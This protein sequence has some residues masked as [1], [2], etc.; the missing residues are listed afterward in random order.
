ML[1]AYRIS[2]CMTLQDCSLKMYVN[3]GEESAWLSRMVSSLTGSYGVCLQLV[4]MVQERAST[5]STQQTIHTQQ[6]VHNVM[7]P[8]N[9]DT[10]SVALRLN[11]EQ[12]SRIIN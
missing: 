9:L 6:E 12:A 8:A 5:V 3:S 11:S 1:N 7:K 10:F 2:N 4:A